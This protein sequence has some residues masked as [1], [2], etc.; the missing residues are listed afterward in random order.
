MGLQYLILMRHA[1]SSWSDGRLSDH[2]RPLNGR[3]RRAAAAIGKVLIARKLVPDMIWSSDS[4]RTRETVEYLDFPRAI[5][6]EYLEGFYHASANNVL[7]LCSERGEPDTGTLMLVG[8]NPAWEELLGHFAKIDRH[9]PTGACAILARKRTNKDWLDPA[10][11][12]LRDYI[13]PRQL[14]E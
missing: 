10:A 5:N 6:T 11:W 4:A 2:K 13:L 14:K 12:R 1:K 7:C 3:G 9:M 8:H